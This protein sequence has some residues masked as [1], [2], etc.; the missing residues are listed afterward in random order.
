MGN[1]NTKTLSFFS[2]FRFSVFVILASG[3]AAAADLSLQK[4]I[5][6]VDVAEPSYVHYTIH[7]LRD[8]LKAITGAAPVLSYDLNEAEQTANELIVVG[9]SMAGRLAQQEQGIPAITDQQPGAQGFILKSLRLAGNKRAILA[10]GSDA[11]GTNYGV[12][13]LRQLLTESVSGLTVSDQLDQR[14]TPRFKVR[15]LYLHQHWR[16][17][18][19]YAAWRWSV[20]DWKHALDIA[21]Y[22]RVNLVMFWPHMD[23]LAPPLSIPERDYLA[24]FREVVDYAHRK[25]GLEVWMVETPNGVLDEPEV[26]RLPLDRRDFYAYE[27]RDGKSKDGHSYPP[28]S[29]LKN[30]GDPKGYAALM[31][32]REALYRNVPNADGYGFIDADTGGWP[33]SPSSA[34]VDMYVGNRK[35][36]DRYHE[37][38]ERAK[39]LYWIGSGWGTGTVEENIQNTVTDLNKRVHGPWELLFYPQYLKTIEKLHFLDRAILFPYGQVEGEPSLPL[40]SINFQELANTVKTAAAEKDLLGIMANVQTLLVQLPNIHYLVSAAWSGK[41]PE[42]SDAAALHSLAKLLFPQNADVLAEGWLQLTAS[43]ADGP[44]AAVQKIEGVLNQHEIG[45]LGTLGE[46][47]FP[48]PGQVL[49]DLVAILK[50]HA[51]AERARE[52]VAAGAPSSEVEQAFAAYFDEMLAWQKQCDF[53]GTYAVNKQVIFDNFIYGRDAETVKAA[54]KQYASGRATQKTESEIVSMLSGKGYTGWI[55]TSV[56]GQVFG[57]YEMKGEANMELR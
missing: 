3:L 43:N 23:M 32:N 30:P 9:R 54:W 28:G 38:P 57:T 29:G 24:D 10:A 8:Q 20:E 7:E 46:S 14:E 52:K 48:E 25:R 17:N 49:Q 27:Y 40:T 4:S 35:L 53:F 19:P 44:L 36:L 56:T 11:H 34:F 22:M 33:G 6:V 42:D 55:V 21:A 51:S 41:P 2:A 37:H 47:I 16:Y 50:I 31:A 12:M 39:L 15:G 1:S 18:W 26:K 5:V 13:E 45:R